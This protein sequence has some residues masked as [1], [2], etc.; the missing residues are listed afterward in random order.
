MSIRLKTKP[1]I[2]RSLNDNDL[3]FVTKTNENTDNPSTF[4]RI[5][6]Q[7]CDFVRILVGIDHYTKT[8]TYSKS[9]TYTQAE[10]DILI[11]AG[12]SSFRQ[13]S[14]TTTL[15]SGDTQIECTANSFT[16]TLPTAVGFSGQLSIK[17]SGSGVIIITTIDG[18][19]T[20]DGDTIFDGLSQYENLIVTSNG[21][22][23]L[24]I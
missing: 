3:I 8:E 14:G 23:W 20:I 21:T 2:G 1:E 13:I 22:N 10:V 4:L 17:N 11:A 19:Q 7:I 6:N 15:L 5:K 12:G 18:V 9:E 16:V 24:I